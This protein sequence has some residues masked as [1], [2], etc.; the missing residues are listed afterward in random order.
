MNWCLGTQAATYL[1]QLQLKLKCFGKMDVFFID[2]FRGG[3]KLQRKEIEWVK[4]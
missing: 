1:N 2:P 3:Y 4:F